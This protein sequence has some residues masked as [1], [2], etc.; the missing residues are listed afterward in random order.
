MYA[1]SA[2]KWAIR[3]K[4]AIT[5]D[6]VMGLDTKDIVDRACCWK[7]CSWRKNSVSKLIFNAND[8]VIGCTLYQQH[9]ERRERPKMGYKSCKVALLHL[10]TLKYGLVIKNRRCQKKESTLYIHPK[11][12]PLCAFVPTLGGTK[13]T[14]WF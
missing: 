7:S 10:Q 1:I 3:I 11:L 12:K 9:I 2:L 14:Q 13:C 8:F 6:W 4:F 5:N